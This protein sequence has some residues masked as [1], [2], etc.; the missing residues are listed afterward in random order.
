M[1]EEQ[2]KNKE[3]R[4]FVRGNNFDVFVSYRRSDGKEF[5]RILNLAFKNEGFRCFLDYDK[6]EGGDFSKQLQDAVVDAPVFVMVLTPDYFARCV[7]KDETR[8]DEDVWIPNEEDWVRRE[9]ELALEKGKIIIPIDK[10]GMLNGTPDYLDDDFRNRVG[11]HQFSP[12]Y[13]NN[14]FEATFGAMLDKNIWNIFYKFQKPTNKAEI[15]V[16]TDADCKLLKNN[17]LL[18][19][20]QADEHSLVLLGKGN[21]LLQARSEEFPEIFIE[22]EK[23]IE[24][25]SCDDFIRIKLKDKVQPLRE[26]KRKKEE[27]EQRLREEKERRRKADEI[28]QAVRRLVHNLPDLH[29]TLTGHSDYVEFVSWSPDGK[30]LASA[31][32]DKTVIIWDAK[33][34]E[35]LKTLK[36]H[37]NFVWSVSWSPDGKYLASGAYQASSLSEQGE[38]II[39]DAK[40]GEKLKTLE[41]HSYDVVS[42]SWSPDG[43]YLASGSDDKTIIIWNANSGEEIK[44][45]KG[46]SDG[47]WSVC[48]SPDGK[49][50]AS[51]S[52]DK[53][54]IIWDAKSGE[55]IQ[56]LK[57]HSESVRS[58][59]WSPDGKYLASRSS[60]NTVVIWDAKSGQ[61]LETL[62][63]HSSTV[64]SVCWSPDGKYLAS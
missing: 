38:I 46:H 58:V 60:N 64:N 26:E 59:C 3:K 13:D 5:A 17:K 2:N 42:V 25:V 8:K 32:K 33:S 30:Y 63:G 36:G 9:I 1:A 35:K 37:S 27:E 61:K 14:A 4:E 20:L 48:W 10:N 23:E 34:G 12:V 49:Y 50:L 15:T 22:I 53:T 16:A 44:T 52:W 28:K 47:V 6:L 19:T 41:G 54:I 11:A 7:K 45:L 57:R 24:D 62:K 21:H 39:W 43:K 31:S 40:S 29:K 56:T 18:A 51:G 55:C